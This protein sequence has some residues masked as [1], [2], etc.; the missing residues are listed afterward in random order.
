[1]KNGLSLF[2]LTYFMHD[3]FFIFLSFAAENKL[4]VHLKLIVLWQP[5]T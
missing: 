5:T 4:L 1:M 2:F 3:V